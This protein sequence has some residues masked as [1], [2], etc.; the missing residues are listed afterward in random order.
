MQN[1]LEP[2]FHKHKAAQTFSSYDAMSGHE[3]PEKLIPNVRQAG[4]LPLDLKRSIGTRVML[5]R[6]LCTEQGLVNGAMG[7]VVEISFHENILRK[8]H[9]KF[10]T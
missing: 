9:V 2:L 3:V 6:N 5:L 10:G 1:K 7:N 8:I 4:G